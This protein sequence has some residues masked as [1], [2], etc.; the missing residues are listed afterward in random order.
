[1]ELSPVSARGAMRGTGTPSQS[2]GDGRVPTRLDE[3]VVAGGTLAY[4]IVLQ[5]V[6]P[7][8]WHM[9]ANAA[10]TL[11]S[12]TFARRVGASSADCGLCL[13]TLAPA[14]RMG[15]AAAAVVAAG[16]AVVSRPRRI[17]ALFAEGHVAGHGSGRDVYEVLVRIPASTALSEEVLF[18]GTMLGVMLRRHSTPAAVVRTSLCFGMWH[19]LPTLASLRYALLSRAARGTVSVPAAPVGVLALTAVAG[20]AFAALRLRSGSVLAPVL[21]HAALNATAYLRARR[22]AGEAIAPRPAPP[23]RSGR[24]AHLTA[25]RGGAGNAATV[26]PRTVGPVRPTGLS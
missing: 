8:R 25:D 6:I 22:A 26:R 16:V 5:R 23:A 4:G 1:M 15:A 24:R 19:V 10:A 12:V 2:R 14:L 3:A 20:A 13:D 18:R 17:R 21:A 11:A 9:P 7:G